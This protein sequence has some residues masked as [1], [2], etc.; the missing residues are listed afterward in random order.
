M[1]EKNMSEIEFYLDWEN[2]P[3]P[4]NGISEIQGRELRRQNSRGTLCL[5]GPSSNIAG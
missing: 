5:P 2:K 1:S 4:I 3:Q